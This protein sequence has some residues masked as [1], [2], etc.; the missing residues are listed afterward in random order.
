MELS[1]QPTLPNQGLSRTI[2]LSLVVHLAVVGGLLVFEALSPRPMVFR[3][4]MQVNLISA[5]P[6][7]PKEMPPPVPAP[8]KEDP[9]W[10]KL[11]AKPDLLPPPTTLA[12]E[13][14]ALEDLS[15]K[16]PDPEP[17]PEISD[18]LME[19]WRN[20][21]QV[22]VPKDSEPEVADIQAAALADAW[23]RLSEQ[24]DAPAPGKA[25]DSQELSRFWDQLESAAN[26]AKPAPEGSAPQYMASVER[27]ISARWSPPDIF[28]E[29]DQMMAVVM[30]PIMRDGS[31]GDARVVESSGSAHFDQAALRSVRLSAPFPPFPDEMKEPRADIR[32]TFTLLGISLR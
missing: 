15:G 8:P 28:H 14:K 11:A 18:D 24:P 27:R 19:W 4:V 16:A 20:Q 32:V 25:S 31:L 22:D 21:P 5:P 10:D 3:D 30:F 12:D 17:A 9:L 13:F 23:K 6:A 7:P 1:P 26:T 29:Q 2:A